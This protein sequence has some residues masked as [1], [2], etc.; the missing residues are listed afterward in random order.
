MKILFDTF[1]DIGNVAN[2]SGVRPH[3]MLEAFRSLGHEVLL[4]EGEQNR[5]NE[6]R[7]HVRKILE[8]LP[9]ENI[10]LCYVEPPSGPFFNTIDLDLLKAVHRKGI[11]TGLFYRDWYWLY[12]EWAWADKSRL[13]IFV[14]T[15]M[16]RRDLKVFEDCCDVVYFPSASGAEI[17]PNAHFR[18]RDVL[19]PA[20]SGAEPPK[21]G[22]TCTILYI[23]NPGEA[24][25]FEDLLEAVRGLRREHFDV[26]LTVVTKFSKLKEAYGGIPEEDGVVFREGS[27]DALLPYYAGADAGIIPR[28]RHFY[29]DHAVPVKLFEYLS[30]GLPVLS[31]DC[32]AMSAIVRDEGCGIVCEAGADGIRDAIRRLYEPGK[33]PALKRAAYETAC[34]NRWEARA[35]KVVDDLT[36]ASGR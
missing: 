20:C 29:M 30:H 12:P 21:D 8:L 23:G 15:Q 31:T 36:G 16:H 32:P 2:G 9:D 7:E 33:L 17:L 27:G 1:S 11:P 34:R 26:K 14:L 22:E 19:P 3:Y 13:K 35:Q 6:R 24:D 5:R 18:K 25:G 10:D 4:L 28:R